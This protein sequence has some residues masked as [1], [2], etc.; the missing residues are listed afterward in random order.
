MPLRVKAAFAA[1]ALTLAATSFAEAAELVMVNARGCSYCAKFKRELEPGYSSTEAGRVAPLR[2]VSAL[3]RWPDD[4]K[5]IPQS[6]YAPVFIL[7][8]KGREVGRIFGYTGAEQFW[9]QLNPMI[10]RL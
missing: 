6:P 1:L 2:V 5:G 7:V 10:G 8:D 3:K 9:S 4:L